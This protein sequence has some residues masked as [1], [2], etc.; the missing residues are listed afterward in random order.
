MGR[1]T[2]GELRPLRDSDTTFAK[3]WWVAKP[4]VSYV[5]MKTSSSSLSTK[6]MGR[7]TVGELRR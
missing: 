5:Y 2:V 3:D 6:L 1:Q 4:L 7:Q